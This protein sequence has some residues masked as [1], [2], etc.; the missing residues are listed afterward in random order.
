M[1]EILVLY[2]SHRGSVKQLAQF[3]ARGIEQVDGIRARLRTVPR[4]S[5]VCEATEADVPD[6]G[7]PYVEVRDLD[8]CIGIAVGSPT[9]FGN[10]AAPLKYFLDGTGAQWHAGTL[11]GKPAAVFTSTASLHGGQE[12]TLLSMML[13]L[14]HHGMLIVGLPYSEADLQ[15]TREGGSPYG[16]SHVAGMAGDAPISDAER[17]LAIALGRR[18]AEVAGKLAG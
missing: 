16:A 13:P 2:Y 12:T 3:V 4:V 15:T 11:Q 1:S 14:L 9:R 7:A 10:M 8:E 6:S 17:R 5:T 18:L